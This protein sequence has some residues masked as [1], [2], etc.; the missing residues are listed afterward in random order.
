MTWPP[1]SST[2]PHQSGAGVESSQ[3]ATNELGGAVGEPSPDLG[4][5]VERRASDS[6]PRRRAQPLDRLGEPDR[7]VR[8]AAASGFSI[9]ERDAALDQPLARSP[10]SRCGGTA[11][12]DDVRTLRRRASAST[13]SDARSA[14]SAGT[15]SARRR[16]GPRDD[17]DQLASARAARAPRGASPA[18]PA[19]RPDEAA[20]AGHPR[21]P[22]KIAR[23]QVRRGLLELVVAAVARAACP[24]ASA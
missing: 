3:R 13:S 10:R 5:D 18:D 11:H 8:V 16:G 24:G 17:P 23:Q 12:V 19:Q 15:A 6:R 20:A 14:P 7:A 2:R 22:P 21:S 9:E 4:Q 1:P